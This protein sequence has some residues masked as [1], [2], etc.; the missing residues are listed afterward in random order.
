M[1]KTTK[2]KTKSL[3]LKFPTEEFKDIIG[4]YAEKTGWTKKVKSSERGSTE[5]VKNPLTQE[6]HVIKILQERLL[7]LYRK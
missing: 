1:A 2:S 7:S 6:Q 5:E 4:S 3:I